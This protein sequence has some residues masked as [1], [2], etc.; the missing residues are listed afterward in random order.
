MPTN[1]QQLGTSLATSEF[2]FGGFA[3]SEWHSETFQQLVSFLVGLG[4]R[5]ESYVHT[6]NPLDL[7]DIDLRKYDLLFQTKRV[8]SAS[9]E[10]L[11]GNAAEIPN[12]RES[13]D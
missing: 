13:P 11:V 3:F 5:H 12:A 9:I 8:V 1:S 7:I 2:P 4:C 6:E 10:R